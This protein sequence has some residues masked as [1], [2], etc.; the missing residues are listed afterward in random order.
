MRRVG[1][2]STF[3]PDDHEG[4]VRIAA[5][6]QALQPFGWTVGRNL[7][8][9]Y[10]WGE[11]GSA[12]TRRKPLGAQMATMTPTGGSRLSDGED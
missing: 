3:T 1:V 4:Q 11:G 5:F 2:L 10:R 12:S 6:L 9:D 7:R 8:I